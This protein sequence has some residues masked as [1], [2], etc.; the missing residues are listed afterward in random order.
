VIKLEIQSVLPLDQA[1]IGGSGVCSTLDSFPP[2][3]VL[4][5]SPD[6]DRSRCRTD[7]IS[8]LLNF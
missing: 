4:P 6:P 8:P 3:I 1:Y 5:S 2:T 7:D